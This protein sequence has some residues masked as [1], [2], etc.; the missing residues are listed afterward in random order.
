M[1]NFQIKVPEC[2]H[3]TV[4][5]MWNSLIN[6]NGIFEMHIIFIH[7]PTGYAEHDLLIVFSHKTIN[8]LK[9]FDAM[10]DIRHEDTILKCVL[11]NKNELWSNDN[12]MN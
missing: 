8:K 6:I 3:L 2:Y 11:P 4:L 10:L 9:E 12:K 5:S 7:S 1:S